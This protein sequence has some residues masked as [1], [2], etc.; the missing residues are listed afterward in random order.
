MPHA[1]RCRAGTWWTA[2]SDT[3]CNWHKTDLTASSYWC[4]LESEPV[5]E[6]RCLDQQTANTFIGCP[7]FSLQPRDTS[8]SC[9]T[10][11]CQPRA[12]IL[13]LMTNKTSP[14]SHVKPPYST[15]PS[16]FFQHIT[17]VQ[18]TSFRSGGDV[19][20]DLIPL[21][22]PLRPNWTAQVEP[23]GSSPHG[24]TFFTYNLIGG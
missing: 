17:H 1:V 9:K 10:N 20:G 22:S 19:I 11:D 24:V 21:K 2:V 14:L 12:N 23:D 8:D 5:E 6:F 13:L 4:H 16:Y 18:R 15:A 3:G 7:V